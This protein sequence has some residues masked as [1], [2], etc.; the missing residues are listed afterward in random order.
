MLKKKAHSKPEKMQQHCTQNN[1]T[2]IHLEQEK[3]LVNICAILFHK[4]GTPTLLERQL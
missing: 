1:K 4:Y 2:Q 3:I